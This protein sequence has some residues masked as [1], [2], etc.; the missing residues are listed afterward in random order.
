MFDFNDVTQEINTNDNDIFTDISLDLLDI[1]QCKLF[2]KLYGVPIIGK[3]ISEI[4]NFYYIDNV[5]DTESYSYVNSDIC[6]IPLQILNNTLTDPKNKFNTLYKD[7]D[8]LVIYKKI[9]NYLEVNAGYIPNFS[10]AYIYENNYFSIF[11]IGEIYPCSNFYIMLNKDKIKKDKRNI[12]NLFNLYNNNAKCDYNKIVK[13][14][15]KVLDYKLY[16]NDITNLYKYPIKMYFDNQI[17]K[18]G[19][20]R[21]YKDIDNNKVYFIYD[22]YSIRNACKFNDL[23]YNEFMGLLSLPND[24]MYKIIDN[25]KSDNYTYTTEINEHKLNI[26]ITSNLKDVPNYIK[27]YFKYN[28][29]TRDRKNKLR[30]IVVDL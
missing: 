8:N 16:I 20:I 1:N 6:N 22:L 12:D 2:Y 11:M 26:H 21:F 30:A 27:I 10:N 15:P 7:I 17:L 29:K 4:E 13:L 25:I 23:M 18:D 28:Y 24:T 19:N 3:S 5:W 9:L 14:L